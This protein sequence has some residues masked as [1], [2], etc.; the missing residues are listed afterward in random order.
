[1]CLRY[2]IAGFVD[3]HLASSEVKRRVRFK[4]NSLCRGITDP[5]GIIP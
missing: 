1:M 3:A 2:G 5:V 4:K